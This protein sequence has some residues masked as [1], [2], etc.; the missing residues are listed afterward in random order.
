MVEVKLSVVFL[1]E[2]DRFIAYSPALDLSTSGH[3]HDEAKK[4]FDEIVQ[5]FIE[6]LTTNGTTEEVLGDLG[7][8]QKEKQWIPPIL[9][10]HEIE[11]FSLPAA[12]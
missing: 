4:R 10:S 5:I 8:R 6:E 12:A 3:T 2:G 7:W 9:V 11:T 1:R